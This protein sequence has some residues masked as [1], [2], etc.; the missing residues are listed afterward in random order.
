M[1]KEKRYRY[2]SPAQKG[3][4]QKWMLAGAVLV[5]AV[6]V[7]LLGTWLRPA[8]EPA[9][10]ILIPTITPVNATGCTS[11]ACLTNLAEEEGNPTLC[12][13]ILNETRQQLCLEKI[14]DVSFDACERMQDY[15]KRKSCAMAHAE[16]EQSIRPCQRLGLAEEDR[17][18]CIRSVDECYFEGAEDQP[19]CRALQHQDVSFCEGDTACVNIYAIQNGETDS[20]EAITDPAEQNACVGL[21][22][23]RSL[24]HELSLPSRQD[25]CYELYSKATNESY[26]GAITEGSDYEWRCHA[27]FAVT[28]QNASQCAATDL[29]GRWKCYRN[30]SAETGDLAGCRA[31]HLLAQTTR[32]NCLFDIVTLY[33]DP[34]ACTEFVYASD[35]ER[36]YSALIYQHRVPIALESCALIELTAWRNACYS[37]VAV[38]QKNSSICAYA[39]TS[40]SKELCERRVSGNSTNTSG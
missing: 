30:Y 40:T 1:P 32:Y 37:T 2:T 20:C 22:L 31:I 38:E 29:L 19:T 34:R 12:D 26:C 11:D 5:A 3:V 8:V 33:S 27:Y 13:L 39:D 21:V 23:G 18:A 36:C 17:D 9:G 4:Q 25:Y 28:Q 16:E 7:I 15:G 35:R 14:A 24:C 6:A 10:D